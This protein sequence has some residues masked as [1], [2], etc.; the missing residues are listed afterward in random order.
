MLS[1]VRREP[2]AVLAL[3]LLASATASAAPQGSPVRDQAPA[4]P[5]CTISGTVTAGLA[6]LPGAAVTVIPKA[7]GDPLLTSTA[8]DGAFRVNPPGP[9]VYDVLV[10]LSAFVSTVKTVTLGPGCQAH[11]EIATT[12]R[13]R[14]PVAPT[15]PPARPA[16]RAGGLT[17]QRVAPVQG[18][19]AGQRGR[20]AAPGSDPGGTGAED[21]QAVAQHLNLPAGFTPE[22]V[23]ETVTRFGSTTQLNLATLFGGRGGE[24]QGG[25]F[26]AAGDTAPAGS[27]APVNA[28]QGAGFA[29]G[30]RG[31]SGG[32]GR[33]G[34][35]AAGMAGLAGLAGLVGGGG[36]AGV[37]GGIPGLGA[38]LGSKISGQASYTLGGSMFDARPYALNGQDVQEPDYTSHRFGVSIGG[39]AKIPGLFDLGSRSSFFLSYSGSRGSNVYDAYS[40]V[41]TL[42]ERAGDFSGGPTIID[43]LTGQPF[44]GNRISADRF[45]QAAV[46]LLRYFPEP[47]QAGSS[48][49][50]HMLGTTT[51]RGDDINLRFARTFG[52][53]Q[54]G[55]IMSSLGRGGAAG[56][57]LGALDKIV[58]FNG[59]VHLSWTRTSQMTAFP[60][61]RGTTRRQGLDVP[62]NLSFG[63]WGLLNTVSVQFN[64]NRAVT[65]NRFGGVT[66]VGGDAGI[67]GVSADPFDWGVPSLSFT[68]IS[69]LRDV[70]P[71]ESVSRTLAATVTM[72]KISGK[73]TIR[74]GGDVRSLFSENRSSADARGSFVFTGMYASGGAGG[75]SGLDVA[76]FLLGLSQQASVQYGP[77][78]E[79][80]A[81]TAF[82]LYVQDD[83]RLSAKV[84]LNLGLRY[85][86]QSPYTEADDRLVTLDAPADFSAAV[87][88][89]AGQDGPYRGRYTRSLVRADAGNVA[90]RL[91]LAWR[92]SSKVVVRGGYS[93]NYASV[94]YL[95]IAQ[96]LAAQPPFATSNSRIGTSSTPLAI[97]TVFA[98]PAPPTTTTNTFGVDPAYGIGYVHIWNADVQ[99]DLARTWIAGL[100]YTGTRGV[101]L[102]LLRAPNRGPAGLRIANVQAFTWES[103]GGTST[104]NSLSVRLRKR[105]SGGVAGG[106]TY[107]LSKSMDNASSIGGGTA[108]VAQDDQNLA[109]EWGRSSFD[110][111]H[112]LSADASVEL[113]FGVGRKWVTEAGLWDTLVGGWQV[114]ANFS[115]ASGI[116]YTARVLGA[117]SDIS[118]GTNGTLRADY[119]GQPITLSHP[120]LAGYFN[121]SAF[122]V[123][124]AGTFGNSARNMITGPSNST[125][126]MSASK[127]FRFMKTRSLS[128]RI[129]ATNVLNTARWGA[130]DTVVNSPTFGR[131]VLVRSMRSVQAVA[132]LMF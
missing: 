82:S 109:A 35:G 83:W 119:T 3:A 16:T 6:R 107:T 8:A 71:S 69:S 18:P 27:V 42:A 41:P 60:E 92:A 89:R 124:A 123:P 75:R 9:G 90:P 85:E 102:D 105:L 25:A 114:T 74:W 78:R 79:R 91:G 14:A 49:N 58:N 54:L 45:S 122:A 88:V 40:T 121:T 131:V 51:S 38:L 26:D 31:L 20:G 22:S 32:G 76:D 100:S 112:Q 28:P 66:D 104:M 103:S 11:V 39:P 93:I 15:A 17:F 95:S 68:S 70:N 29:A 33:G 4:S 97:G 63:K 118:R 65:T 98:T 94:P 23:A 128:L 2:L 62:L 10:E 80:F 30:A 47:N 59:G 61:L 77:G 12:L 7:G 48:Q 111:R 5:P 126:N 64:R 106:V 52:T 120:T 57:M 43:P 19:T 116:P 1:P 132:R 46:S 37:V 44:P 50:Y 117:A 72:M 36:L 108:V 53:P 130:I 87:P 127:S 86:F 24:G 81:A 115:W 113:P 96:R 34:G 84:T 110:Q 129:Q 56:G 101:S 99:Y 21:V 67:A 73:H 125:L 55:R 13:S